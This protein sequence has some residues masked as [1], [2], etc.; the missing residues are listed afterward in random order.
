MD[1]S[2]Y[3]K[4][5][6]GKKQVDRREE[7]KKKKQNKTLI[8]FNLPHVNVNIVKSKKAKVKSQVNNMSTN[9]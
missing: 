4:V 8:R 2:D 9:F 3:C 1:K 5:R 7:K 6:K